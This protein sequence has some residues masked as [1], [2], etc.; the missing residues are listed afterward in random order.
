MLLL[1]QNSYSLKE[2]AVLLGTKVFFIEYLASP[3]KF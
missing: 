1:G 2:Y 3:F